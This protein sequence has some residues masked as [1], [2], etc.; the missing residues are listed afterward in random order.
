MFAWDITGEAALVGCVPLLEWAHGSFLL[1]VSHGVCPD[2]S[3]ACQEAQDE[4]CEHPLPWGWVWDRVPA[5]CAPGL[6]P[7]IHKAR[8]CLLS[9]L[10]SPSQ[11]EERVFP[12]AC[13]IFFFFF[14][15]KY[16]VIRWV[17]LLECTA[18]LPTMVLSANGSR[19]SSLH[20]R[21]KLA[22][23]NATGFWTQW[24]SVNGT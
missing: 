21:S 15:K 12:R 24:V 4:H 17:C 1:G 3:L 14:Q 6:R 18:N 5:S 19:T 16:R 10:L 9:T 7:P 20:L 8:R 23:R 22:F 11:W 2:M 13:C